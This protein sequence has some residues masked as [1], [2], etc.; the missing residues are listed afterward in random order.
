[1]NLQ[2]YIS[3]GIVESYVLGLASTEEQREFE[4]YCAQHPELV[5]A[6]ERFEESL[7]KTAMAGVAV[8]P[9][10]TIKEN[11]WSKI[12]ETEARVVSLP[13][14]NN[15]EP[16][17]KTASARSNWFRYVA[18]ASIILLA[19]STILNFYFYRQYQSYNERYNE[20][21]ASTQQMANANKALQT[22][23]EELQSGIRMMKDPN[24][25]PIAMKGT[26][27][28]PGSLATV[29]WNKTTSDVY[30]LVNNLPAPAADQQY[31]LWAFVD[32]TPVNAGFVDMQSADGM[33]KMKNF[34]RAELFA[35][36]L[37]KKD[38]K[39]ITTPQGPVYVL[40]KI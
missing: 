23:N 33:I 25:Q 21:Y 35:I 24:T 4:Q 10:A 31:Q 8:A 37:E 14:N 2:E 28:S 19:G 39:D 1:V 6:R 16:A 38:R 17:I 34:A 22:R 26:P 29:Y 13:Q 36:T 20:L 40:G 7:E 30:V 18:A 12:K 11:V 9:P 3:S 15:S 27:A 5:A 32:G